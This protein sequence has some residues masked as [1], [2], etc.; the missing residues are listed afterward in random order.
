MKR[1]HLIMKKLAMSSDSDMRAST[2]YQSD[3]KVIRSNLGKGLVLHDIDTTTNKLYFTRS[4]EPN[5][6]GTVQEYDKELNQLRIIAGNGVTGSY[7]PSGR[8]REI[9]LGN[10]ADAKVFN[11]NFILWSIY[12]LF[13]KCH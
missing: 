9:P 4:D 1:S 2:V 10:L 13:V 3:F 6:I 5:K 12:V 7:Y 11:H 8:A